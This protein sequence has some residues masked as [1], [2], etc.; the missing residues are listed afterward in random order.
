MLATAV[1]C[2]RSGVRIWHYIAAPQLTMRDF[3][4]DFLDCYL[5]A[6]AEAV[7]AT[8]GAYRLEGLGAHLFAVIEGD[9]SAI[10]GLPLLPLLEFLR[11]IRILVA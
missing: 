3:S 4:D 9:Y 11:E 8:V 2:R 7:T 5:A 10:L 6:E 1:V